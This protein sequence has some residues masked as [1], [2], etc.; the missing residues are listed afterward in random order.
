MKTHRHAPEPT[1]GK[2]ESKRTQARVPSLFRS[3]RPSR[4]DRKRSAL[5]WPKWEREMLTFLAR[6]GYT[7]ETE[8]AN[9]HFIGLHLSSPI[10]RDMADVQT[11]RNVIWAEVVPMGTG[12]VGD[13]IF[14][15]GHTIG[16]PNASPYPTTE[17]AEEVLAALLAA[18]RWAPPPTDV[19]KPVDVPF[20]IFDREI[21]LPRQEVEE[22]GRKLSVLPQEKRDAV[23]NGA[24]MTLAAFTPDGMV[25]AVSMSLPVSVALMALAAAGSRTFDQY[26]PLWLAVNGRN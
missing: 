19:V 22:A 26:D 2:Q 25:D 6:H 7:D 8:A 17:A 11:W 23:V 3:A 1:A 13:V 24:R 20:R 5:E 14:C 21:Y 9:P 4:F 16:S 15:A 18:I 12:F 10:A